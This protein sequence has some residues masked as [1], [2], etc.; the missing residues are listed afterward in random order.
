MDS[1]A[2]PKVV[3]HDHL[4]GGLRP[5]TVL[6]LADAIG[7][8]GLPASDPAA[9]ANWFNQSGSQSLERYLEAFS[10]TLAVMQ[11]PEALRRVAYEA[12]V[13]LATD[14]VVYAEIR[15]AP[16]LHTARG[17][18]LDEVIGAVRDG[19]AAGEAECGIVVRIIVDAMRQLDE[20]ERVAH[21]AVGF[22]GRGVVGFD[23]AGPEAGFPA[24]RHAA[25]CGI[26]REGGLHLTVHAGEGDGPSSIADAVDG[27]GAERIGHGV[28]IVEDLDFADGEVVGAGSIAETVLDGGIPLEVCPSSNVDTGLYRT[29]GDH[30]VGLLD[31]AGFRVTLNTD[32][33]LMTGTSMSR[34][35]DLTA[36]HQGFTVEDFRRV[37]LTAVDAA[38]CDENTRA[39]VRD[40]VV[41]G[42]DAAG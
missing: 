2:L 8:R 1:V 3:L 30:P 17:L 6:D 41:A 27:C 34:E 7:Y 21:T 4:D 16:E 12:A 35:F 38:F 29:I 10:E 24:S 31:R 22:A 39:A 13:D 32:N 36:V 14:G 25:A 18:T 40:R 37:T 11:T 33:R 28:R 15:F 23:L 26:A 9:L 5:G 42:Y 20:S 19:G